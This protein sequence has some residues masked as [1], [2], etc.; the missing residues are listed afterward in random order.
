MLLWWCK[1][2]GK[3]DPFAFLDLP[4]ASDSHLLKNDML[5]IFSFSLNL[6]YEGSYKETYRKLNEMHWRSS[7]I[8][9]NA[10]P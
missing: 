9:H 2:V 4:T 5:W 6:S 3:R 10:A 1:D 7:P 8:L